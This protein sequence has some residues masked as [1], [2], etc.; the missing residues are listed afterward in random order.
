MESK[1]GKTRKLEVYWFTVSYKQLV[2]WISAISL[3]VALGGFA[4]FKEYV[5]RKY[6]C[7]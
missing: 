7:F 5:I 2:L 6:K 4:F 1:V 3:V